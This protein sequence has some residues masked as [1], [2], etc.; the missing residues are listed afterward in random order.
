MPNLNEVLVFL[1][2]L[3]VEHTKADSSIAGIFFSLDI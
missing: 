2:Y 1:Q 3:S